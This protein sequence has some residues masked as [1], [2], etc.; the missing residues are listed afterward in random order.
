MV[1]AAA[2]FSVADAAGN[3]LQLKHRPLTV[4]RI[5]QGKVERAGAAARRLLASSDEVTGDHAEVITNYMDAQYYGEITS[6]T[7]GQSFEVVFDTGSSNLWVPSKKCAWYQLACKLHNQYDSSASSTYVANGTQFAI[8]PLFSVWFSR[9]A[10]ASPGGEIVFGGTNPD[11]FDGNH[12]YVPV[13][14][15]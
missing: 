5:R 3:T 8:Q 14:R 12:T 2:V 9:K 15:E 11:H 1:C 13:T 6:G 10:N 7:P 4:E